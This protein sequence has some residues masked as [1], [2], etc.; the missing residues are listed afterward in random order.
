MARS[1]HHGSQMR[2]WKPGPVG[3]HR[4]NNNK[5][6]VGKAGVKSPGWEMEEVTETAGGPELLSPSR[7]ENAT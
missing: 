2:R 7:R 6:S 5:W 4:G 3:G 1:K